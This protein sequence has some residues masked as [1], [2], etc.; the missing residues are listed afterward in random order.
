MPVEPAW[1]MRGGAFKMSNYRDASNGSTF[2]MRINAQQEFE[3]WRSLLVNNQWQHHRVTRFGATKTV[4]PT[5]VISAFTAVLGDPTRTTTSLSLKITHV[6]DTL[7]SSKRVA[8]YY[9]VSQ[10]SLINLSGTNVATVYDAQS[11]L[12]IDQF[13][14][15]ATGMVPNA[16]SYVIT[17]LPSNTVFNQVRARI[18]N[19]F[20]VS[21]LITTTVSSPIPTLDALGPQVV[22]SI[23]VTPNDADLSLSVEMSTYDAGLTTT[24]YTV[25]V[26]VSPLPTYNTTAITASTANVSTYTG[27]GKTLE[28][29]YTSTQEISVDLT[30][31]ALVAGTA[32]YVYYVLYDPLGNRTDNGMTVKTGYTL[33]EINVYYSNFRSIELSGDAANNQYSEVMNWAPDT[34]TGTGLTV[35]S[36]IYPK[37]NTVANPVYVIGDKN[38]VSTGAGA[39]ISLT[40]GASDRSLISTW[41]ATGS[42][43]SYTSIPT[44]YNEWHHVA[45][46]Y[47]RNQRTNGRSLTFNGSSQYATTDMTN[48]F[49]YKD[50]TV[51]AWIKRSSTNT[52]DTIYHPYR[53]TNNTE[54]YMFCIEGDGK[55]YVYHNTNL[56]SSSVTIQANIWYHVGFTWDASDTIRIYVNGVLS[57][58][59][60]STATTPFTGKIDLDIGRDW[61][62]FQT[63]EFFGGSLDEYAIWGTTLDAT[64]IAAVYNAGQPFDL[65]SAQGLYTQSS[66][67]NA[68]YRFEYMD[69]ADLSKPRTGSSVNFIK[70]EKKIMSGADLLFTPIKT[71]PFTMSVWI[72]WRG[73]SPSLQHGVVSFGTP[74]STSVNNGN[75][76]F[77][78]IAPEGYAFGVWGV[79]SINVPNVVP[80]TNTWVHVVFVNRP[81]SNNT[82]FYINGIEYVT[83]AY[84]GTYTGTSIVSVGNYWSWFNSASTLYAFD[85]L[86]DEVGIYNTAITSAEAIAIYNHGVPLDL[87]ANAENYSSSSSLKAYWKFDNSDG[88][89]S[90]SNGKH[91]TT[92]SNKFSSDVPMLH[93]L[94]LVGSPTFTTDAPGPLS[95]A[96]NGSTQYASQTLSYIGVAWSCSMWVKMTAIPTSG[97]GFLFDGRT[98]T[99]SQGSHILWEAN[100]Q[101]K[102][103]LM[104]SYEAT[105]SLNDMLWHHVCLVSNGTTNLSAYLDGSLRISHST[106]TIAE[107][108]IYGVALSTRGNSSPFHYFS[109]IFDD[110]SMWSKALSITEIAEIYNGG[111]PK[112]LLTHSASANLQAYW[113][114]ESSNGN[115]STAYARHLTLTGSPTFSTDIPENCTGKMY[116]DGS[117]VATRI[118][119]PLLPVIRPHVAVG[120]GYE[121]GAFTAQYFKGSIDE[122]SIFSTAMTSTEVAALY[123]S[124]NPPN[125]LQHSRVA[126]L[127]A[128]WQ[129]Q[130]FT[131]NQFD[132]KSSYGRHLTVNY[133]GTKVPQ[134]TTNTVMY[135]LET[136]ASYT[137]TTYTLNTRTSLTPDKTKIIVMEYVSNATFVT[138]RAFD[139]TTYT[140]L[141]VMNHPFSAAPNS[142]PMMNCISDNV[143]V[144]AYRLTSSTTIAYIDRINFNNTSATKDTSTSTTYTLPVS[145]F[146]VTGVVPLDLTGKY[147]VHFSYL[148]SGT[149]RYLGNRYYGNGTLYNTIIWDNV[150]WDHQRAVAVVPIYGTGSGWDLIATPVQNKGVATNN[151]TLYYIFGSGTSIVNTIQQNI[152]SVAE[153]YGCTV[154]GKTSSENILLEYSYGSPNAS[155]LVLVNGFTGAYMSARTNVGAMYSHS[156]NKIVPYK[157][158]ALRFI[159]NSTLTYTRIQYIDE[160][161]ATQLQA[162]KTPYLGYYV[163]NFLHMIEQDKRYVAMMYGSTTVGSGDQSYKFVEINSTYEPDVEVDGILDTSGAVA[164]YGLRKVVSS[165]TGAVA[166]V[167]R[168]GDSAYADVYMDAC[169]NV[170]QAVLSSNSVLTPHNITSMPTVDAEGY[171]VITSPWGITQRIKASSQYDEGTD[172]RLAWN[173]LDGTTVYGSG[174][175]RG[176]L[177]NYGGSNTA[178]II[179]DL[180]AIHTVSAVQYVGY[181]EYS[182]NRW[183]GSY[184]YYWSNNGTTWTQYTSRTGITNGQGLT[185]T[186]TTLVSARYLKLE[187]TNVGSELIVGIM[188]LEIRGLVGV[189]QLSPHN[190]Y[191]QTCNLITPNNLSAEPPVDAEG[192][193]TFAAPTLSGVTQR[194]KAS[195]TYPGGRVSWHVFDGLNTYGVAVPQN[196]YGWLANTQSANLIIDLGQMFHVAGISYYGY[197]ENTFWPTSYSYYA[198]NDGVTWGAAIATRTG[199]TSGGNRLIARSVAVNTRYLRLDFTA[200]PSGWP[201]GIH[202][203]RIQGIPI[204]AEGFYVFKSPLNTTQ[205]IKASSELASTGSGI[206]LFNHQYDAREWQSSGQ[207]TAHLIYDLGST[208]TVTSI[209]HLGNSSTNFPVSYTYSWSNDGTS[210]TSYAT[211]T[212]ITNGNTTDITDTNR[213]TTRYLKLEYTA[214]GGSATVGIYELEVQGYSAF[215]GTLSQDGNA[216]LRFSTHP[217]WRASSGTLSLVSWYDQTGNIKHLNIPL[218][219]TPTISSSMT[220]LVFNGSTTGLYLNGGVLPAGHDEYTM[221]ALWKMD[222]GLTVSANVIEQSAKPAVV[223]GRGALVM[224]YSTSHAQSFIGGSNNIEI[225]PS[226]TY[227]T[228]TRSIMQVNNALTRNVE[229]M[230]NGSTFVNGTTTPSS[231]ALQASWFGVGVNAS[232]T[233]GGDRFKGVINEVIVFNKNIT[234]TQEAELETWW[235]SARMISYVPFF[236][237][238]FIVNVQPANSWVII[239]EIKTVN[240][241]LQAS[242]VHSLSPADLNTSIPFPDFL[243]DGYLPA[244]GGTDPAY[245]TYLTPLVGTCLFKLVIPSTAIISQIQIT[246]H[247]YVYM[248]GF[249]IRKNGV[250]VLT[251]TANGGSDAV[252][253]TITKT[254]NV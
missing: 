167:Q 67:L 31:A 45:C 14:T 200:S 118:G 81:A 8:P 191:Q 76:A 107:L 238:E 40:V 133:S 117:L 24:D 160:T 49:K 4:D 205:R 242:Q 19:Q 213:I 157:Q 36:W 72:K 163:A 151:N 48:W 144:I 65:R 201:V 89:D 115:D 166:L 219:A 231:L 176:W 25:I 173:V 207:T 150:T 243:V 28:T 68:Y 218:T 47:E 181:S 216:L 134:M 59:G 83:A 3:V 112:N 248:P 121:S 146:A 29:A 22:S 192:F 85:G 233:S 88:T 241:T 170:T 10:V 11:E 39:H 172:R 224:T 127:Q 220:N 54:L 52:R 34:S 232:S 235:K 9:T 225:T 33:T 129:M 70:S 41:G 84:T 237:Y 125:V 62:R 141:W 63:G 51:S 98:A 227:N 16:S 198:S 140:Q 183:P 18:T 90:S 212:G 106:T 155:V 20:G 55:L 196:R 56:V 109:G 222:S 86:I 46:T 104:S 32:Y 185:V 171:Y 38:Y 23:T 12:V 193:Y 42:D 57:G 229:L 179:Y 96:F 135:S 190:M 64:A 211:R 230:T 159:D 114:F 92:Y 156:E 116:V 148:N 162:V 124:G 178:H 188:E 228:M 30:G 79:Q 197:G 123:N 97:Y 75:L 93:D 164:A 204:D 246:Y 209:K 177:S 58:Q 126:E 80:P 1:M 240:Y 66:A 154:F 27:T 53:T 43:V 17:G 143:L 221:S 94:T 247:R 142:N 161:S 175:Q 139:T 245:V 103:R 210:W 7:Y 131:G 5:S 44:I 253:E 61:A 128:Y 199:I 111:A 50:F 195:S 203:L 168:S 130:D 102:L 169:K 78:Q 145:G 206:N 239:T 250:D 252:S 6:T 95:I 194:L 136:K 73:E 234:I 137:P 82:A 254:Y 182:N 26:F 108:S 13:A 15:D 21:A 37:T 249:K 186:D 149:G 71:Q 226:I 208:Y 69:G 60:S 110:V 99:Q 120:R 35:S 215:T 251:E 100:N 236:E 223:N 214:A 147:I 138:M 101:N 119:N 113:R 202:E 132:D 91:L 74:S 87:L 174:S 217:A 77:I 184:I 165:Y 189:T 122:M 158:G 2:T 153:T 180:G 187:Y 105:A 152:N 244:E